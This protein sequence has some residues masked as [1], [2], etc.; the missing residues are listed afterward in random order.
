MEI[1]LLVVFMERPPKVLSDLRVQ[2][3]QHRLSLIPETQGLAMIPLAGET[4]SHDTPRA[5][6]AA[7]RCIM[8][9]RAPLVGLSG[10]NCSL[11]DRRAEIRRP[12]PGVSIYAYFPTRPPAVQRTVVRELSKPRGV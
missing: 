12:M 5:Y 2:S 1:D 9:C 3:Q 7:A 4:S 10:Q 11:P 6:C 8:K